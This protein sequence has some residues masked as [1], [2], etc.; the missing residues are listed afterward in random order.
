M[1]LNDKVQKIL[2]GGDYNPEQ[3][4]E[5]VWEEDM[6]LFRLAHIDV[7][8]LNVFSWA[9]LQPDEDTYDFSRLDRIMELVKKNGIKVCLATS[10]A[11]HP[12]W[13]ARKHPDILRVERTGMKRKFGS[14]HN[15]CPNSPTYRKYSVALA[16]KLAERYRDY[17][18]IVAWHIA[19]EYGGECYCDNCEKAFRIWLKEKYGTIEELNRVWNTA[20]WSHTM[21]DFEDVVVPDLRSEEF[22]WGGRMATIALT[23]TVFWH[24]TGWRKRR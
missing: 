13:M 7:V 8:T 1:I 12:A 6:R 17:D 2:F 22:E 24:A 11:A 5:E 10:T 19:N 20:F 9:A 23:L 18:N 4:P 15:S 21:Y 16:E 14:R 3:W